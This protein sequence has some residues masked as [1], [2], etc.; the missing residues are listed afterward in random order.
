[1]RLTCVSIVVA[2]LVTAMPAG[3]GQQAS[4]A[5]QAPQAVQISASV[6]RDVRF[7][8]VS[9]LA[10][11]MDVYK[12]TPGNGRGIVV[13]PGSG[14]R[15]GTAYDAPPNTELAARAAP[16]YIDYFLAGGYTVFIPNVRMTPR[17]TYPDPV[18]DVQRAVKFIRNSAAR[19]G[20]DPTRLG[21]F[22]VSSGGHLASLLGVVEADGS[23][24]DEDAVEKQSA[25]VQAVATVMGVFDLT[26]LTAGRAA[27]TR[28]AFI[29]TPGAGEK[30]EDRRRQA[31]P[32]TYVSGDDAPM[33][34]IHGDADETVP[35]AQS[36]EM[37]Q[38]LTRAG[39]PTR[40]VVVPGGGHGGEVIDE[41]RGSF[42]R[43]AIAWFDLYLG[44]QR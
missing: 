9:G 37:E 30:V 19:W 44:V 21:A 14:W 31:S 43:E 11:V 20:V 17:F 12:P 23:A 39:V 33:L 1:M 2:G 42:M 22:G 34:L 15:T 6:E 27:E 35:I 13:I 41:Q 8:W 5:P 4:Q 32:V 7:G 25:R 26:P 28:D 16:T 40:L 3:A 29:G 18:L 24:S 10:L 38:A 36:Q